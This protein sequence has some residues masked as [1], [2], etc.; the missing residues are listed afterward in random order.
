[1]IQY[2]VIVIGSWLGWLSAAAILAR[3][4]KKV[5]VLE[6]HYVAWWYATNFKRR[7]YE[8]DVALHQIWAE[9]SWLKTILKKAWV[10]DRVKFIKHKYLYESIYPDFEIKVENGSGNMFQKDLITL[11]PDEKFGIKKW[12]FVM[13]YIWMQVKIWDFA[14]RYKFFL[15][16][17]MFFAPI[18][19]P[20]LVFWWKLKLRTI[21]DLCTQNPKLRKVLME[22]LWYFWDNLDISAIYYFIPSYWY[23]FHGWYSIQ[24]WWQALSDAFVDVIVENGW[25]VLTNCEV[26]E[27]IV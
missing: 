23:Y 4:G 19:I 15:P 13:K 25:T 11:F 18:L 9:S 5:L 16:L 20:I 24:W 21:L 7:G 6:K 26:Q 3:R 17:V 2:D 22:I 14:N 12:F 1:M 8:F 10:Y 27:I